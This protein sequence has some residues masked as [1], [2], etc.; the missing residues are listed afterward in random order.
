MV[1]EPRGA[2]SSHGIPLP[3]FSLPARGEVYNM[4]APVQQEPPFV[5]DHLRENPPYPQSRAGVGKGLTP[6][7]QPNS[8]TSYPPLGLPMLNP[9]VWRAMGM[10]EHSGE[11]IQS[12]QGMG[13]GGSG[14]GGGG[15]RGPMSFQPPRSPGRGRRMGMN[16]GTNDRTCELDTKPGEGSTSASSLLRSHAPVVCTLFASIHL[17]QNKKR[18]K[19]LDSTCLFSA[20]RLSGADGESSA[21]SSTSRKSKKK[22]KEGR[23]AQIPVMVEREDTISLQ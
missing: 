11:D 22:G 5:E 13:E 23:G 9:A 3:P 2:Q 21:A 1:T 18:F 12:S 14:G 16:D 6:R 19:C 4:H 7:A 15:D 17:V 20:V 8:Y 10:P